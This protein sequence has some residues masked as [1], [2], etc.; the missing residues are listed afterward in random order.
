MENLEETIMSVKRYMT[1]TIATSVFHYI[2]GNPEENLPKLLRLA[3]KLG[4]E[5]KLVEKLRPA[6]ED[7]DN[8]WHQFAMGLFQDIDK[9][10]QVEG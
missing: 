9:D 7:A 10:L 8:N 3:E 1:K 2:S 4:M 6:I 5:K